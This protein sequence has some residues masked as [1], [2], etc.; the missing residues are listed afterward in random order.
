[1]ASSK[2]LYSYSDIRLMIGISQGQ[3][4][5]QLGVSVPYYSRLENNKRCWTMSTAS[6]WLNFVLTELEKLPK[7][8]VDFSRVPDFDDIEHMNSNVPKE[9]WL[10]G[11][12]IENNLF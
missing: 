10:W 11:Y 12:E 3:M 4:A 7:D 6:K 1:M 9:P 8:T 5:E 2:S